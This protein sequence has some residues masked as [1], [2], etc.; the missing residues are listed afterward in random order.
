[1]VWPASS[2]RR[3]ESARRPA[4]PVGLT[5]ARARNN[6][7]SSLAARARSSQDSDT[8]SASIG[9][10]FRALMAF[11]T[12]RMASVISRGVYILSLR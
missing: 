1:M 7:G 4:K 2:Q 11:A 3:P 8:A 9:C 6:A 12:L 10:A 5:N